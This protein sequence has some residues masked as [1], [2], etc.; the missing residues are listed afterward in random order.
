MIPALLG[1]L[2]RRPPRARRAQAPHAV[3]RGAARDRAQAGRRARVPGPGPALARAV[4]GDGG[5]L[6]VL[7]GLVQINPIWLWGPYHT[8]SATNGAQP[9]WYLGWLIGALRIMPGFDLT[10]GSYTLVP[11]PFWGGVALPGVFFTFLYLWPFLERRFVSHDHGY[12][13]LLDRPRDAPLRTAI[14]MAVRR[15]S[16]SIFLAGQRRPRGRPLRAAVRAANLGLPGAGV[17]RPGARGAARLPHVHRAAARR[18]GR[19]PAQARRGVAPDADRAGRRRS[20]RPTASRSPLPRRSTGSRTGSDPELLRLLDELRLDGREMRGRCLDVESEEQLAHANTIAA[21]A[22]DLAERLVQ[23]RDGP[24]ARRGASWRWARPARSRPGRGSARLPPRT[25]GWPLCGVGARD[26][27][28]P[29][30]AGA[31][32]GAALI[33]R[34]A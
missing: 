19:A 32:V 7:G 18:A 30:C 8:Y 25:R 34:S 13:N 29:P 4:H 5:V 11:N 20:P 1:N 33:A 15:R 6:F 22:A 17:R 26:A 12:H 27:T 21:S 24:A 3:P 28:A 31:R 9:D 16:S 23:G 10:I 2:A 14:G